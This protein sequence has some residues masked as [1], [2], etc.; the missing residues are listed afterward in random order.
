MVIPLIRAVWAMGFGA[1][2]STTKRWWEYYGGGDT[3]L[4]L[5]AGS[6]LRSSGI[7]PRRLPVPGG[8][9]QEGSVT[10]ATVPVPGTVPRMWRSAYGK[11]SK[12][13]TARY[14]IQRRVPPAIPRTVRCD[15]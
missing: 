12:A 4:G 6:G 11:Y 3:V 14:F 7:F 9:A 5:L 8:G 15:G 2:I 1:T 13:P 10:C